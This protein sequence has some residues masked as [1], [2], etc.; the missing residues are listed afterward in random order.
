M[1]RNG[2]AALLVL[3]GFTWVPALW[4]EQP[5]MSLYGRPIASIAFEP[6]QQPLPP[7]QIRLS[8]PL[9]AGDVL[10]EAALGQ[11]IER[12]YATGRYED[13]VV[14]GE[15]APTGVAITFHTRSKLFLSR[16]SVDG[17]AQPPSGEQL[18]SA[19]ALNLG[20][21]Y[22][23]ETLATAVRQMQTLLRANGFFASTIRYEIQNRDSAEQAELRF[24]VEPGHRARF[25]T[26]LI[27][28]NPKFK[29][30]LIIRATGWPNPFSL[31][32]WFRR[33]TFSEWREV[34]DARVQRGLEKVRNAYVKKGFLMAS[35]HLADLAHN[36]AGVGS[37]RVDLQACKL[38]YSIVSPK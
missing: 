24:V 26:P 22:D 14:S 20:E 10:D 8:V 15:P 16:I 35:V 7:E 5:E 29:P 23:D 17:S 2:A 21:S 30:S 1:K 31:H 25:I 36:E 12:L 9:H 4:A 33:G 34:T 6:A 38:E 32:S 18:V 37:S 11:A 27:E 3:V 19:S 13:I 28:G